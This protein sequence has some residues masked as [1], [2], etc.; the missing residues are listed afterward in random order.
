MAD[1]RKI[2]R[3]F[4]RAEDIVFATAGLILT[5]PVFAIVPV[6]SRIENPKGKVYFKQKRVG[7]KGEFYALKFRTMNET[8]GDGE[9]WEN[10]GNMYD[11]TDESR[12][13]RLGKF[14]RRYSIDEF[15]QF[16]NILK[17]EMSAVG[18]RTVTPDEKERMTEAGH[19][20]RFECPQG[21]TGL[22]QM[23]RNWKT[24][25]DA[26]LP[27]DIEYVNRYESRFIGPTDAG[28]IFDTVTNLTNG[29]GKK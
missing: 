21:L 29:L 3:Y 16:I 2:N 9:C 7:N 15:P 26:T 22:A 25:S 13:T 4:K 14:L 12:V 6:L 27:L 8:E 5:A 1:Y 19:G 18:P 28:I 11:F 20:R 24:N 17:G 10:D 23:D